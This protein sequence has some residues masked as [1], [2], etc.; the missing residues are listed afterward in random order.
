MNTVNVTESP[1]VCKNSSPAALRF[2]VTDFGVSSF[3]VTE[4][5]PEPQK[6][7]LANGHWFPTD[8]AFVVYYFPIL[9]SGAVK[10]YIFLECRADRKTRCLRMEQGKIAE[11]SGMS[12]RTVKRATKVLV[13]YQLLAVSKD[14]SPGGKYEHNIYQLLE[15]R[16]PVD[17]DEKVVASDHGSKMAPGD[18]RALHQGPKRTH[19]QEVS[20]SQKKKKNLPPR[21]ELKNSRATPEAD[22]CREQIRTYLPFAVGRP[23]L[24]GKQAEDWN[25]TA[26][27]A[28][29][30]KKYTVEQIKIAIDRCV[31]KKP[32]WVPYVSEVLA[33]LKEMA[34]AAR[35]MT[36]VERMGAAPTA[37]AS[38]AM[39]EVVRRLRKLKL[40]DDE[41]ESWPLEEIAKSGSNIRAAFDRYAEEHPGEFPEPE[42]IIDLLSEAANIAGQAR[43]KPKPAAAT[44]LAST[45]VSTMTQ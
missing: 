27:D 33:E 1:N 30:A 28:M 29:L 25:D 20:Q 26:L 38:C 37:V 35:P 16:K 2:V 45:N 17:D 41:I 12:K 23:S 8:N 9:D 14:R 32:G 36:L 31:K 22:S 10:L 7:G 40:Y 34:K 5:E 4:F 15:V 6:S 39:Q 42:D 3:T 18:W 43:K 19:Y 13:K 11:M 24:S 21:R 44:A